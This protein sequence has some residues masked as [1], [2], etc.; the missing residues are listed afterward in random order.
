MFLTR[1][2]TLGTIGSKDSNNFLELCEVGRLSDLL[3]LFFFDVWDF[4]PVSL[5]NSCVRPSCE[6]TIHW[7]STTV[8]QGRATAVL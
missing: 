5:D 6:T 2:L 1:K 8:P 3:L 4:V 7:L